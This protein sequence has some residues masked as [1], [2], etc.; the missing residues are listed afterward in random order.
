[1]AT[2]EERIERLERRVAGLEEHFNDVLESLAERWATLSDAA[3]VAAAEIARVAKL[4]D[5]V[6][7][8]KAD[9]G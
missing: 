3:K 2:A 6:E 7:K 1:M 8:R 5:K 9:G 4:R